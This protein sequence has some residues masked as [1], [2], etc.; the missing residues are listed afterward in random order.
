LVFL[1]QTGSQS[2]Y[3]LHFL[4]SCR[5][6]SLQA[7]TFF[8]GLKRLLGIGAPFFERGNFPGSFKSQD[9]FTV[10]FVAF[11]GPNR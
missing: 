4:T 7:R 1:S 2:Q 6:P 10:A 9:T 3:P 11:F 5:P 8:G